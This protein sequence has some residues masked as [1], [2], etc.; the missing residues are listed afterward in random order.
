[1]LPP[2]WARRG[3]VLTAGVVLACSAGCA[4]RG[5]WMLPALT[6]GARA[7][8]PTSPSSDLRSVVMMGL[9]WTERSASR[10]IALGRESATESTLEALTSSAP[11]CEVIAACSWE[12]RARASALLRL[13]AVL[14]G[15]ER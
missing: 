10:P 14:S 4:P 15:G 2:E 13:E 5:A 8:V 1:M 11:A 9:R 7:S 3:G 6:L 12:Q